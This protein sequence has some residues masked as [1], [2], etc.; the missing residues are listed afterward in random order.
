MTVSRSPF[1]N[2]PAI[3]T[4]SNRTFRR[5]PIVTGEKTRDEAAIDT[6][7][8]PNLVEHRA[9][10]NA[11]SPVSCSGTLSRS[12]KERFIARH[13]NLAAKYAIAVTYKTAAVPRRKAGREIGTTPVPS[14][15]VT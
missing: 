7:W 10:K 12:S 13:R 8:I 4:G 14:P 5:S 3:A 1:G 11:A 15:I 6:F 9:Q 2:T